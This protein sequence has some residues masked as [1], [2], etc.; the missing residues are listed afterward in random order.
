MLNY[1]TV[2]TF[3]RRNT[4]AIFDRFSELMTAPNNSEIKI[5]HWSGF[6]FGYSLNSR[7][8][9]ISFVMYFGTLIYKL[10]DRTASE[11]FTAINILFMASAAT[12]MA[13][14]NIPSVAKAT[15]SANKI[16][17]II[18]EKSTLDSRE[19][20]KSKVQ[21]IEKGHIVFKNV[22]FKYPQREK[23]VLNR[24][25]LDIAPRQKIA[26]VGSSGCGKSTITNLILRFY[27]IDQGEITVVGNNL[28]DINVKN[29][30]Q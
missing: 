26:L 21:H 29:L 23:K 6:W 28:N 8:I 9:F 25:N 24:L 4:Q 20:V 13:A 12:G 17:N 27:N 15:N 22:N 2:N 1:K 3:G 19:G 11:I 18:D 7:I 30:R 5:A 10:G 14:S 16:F